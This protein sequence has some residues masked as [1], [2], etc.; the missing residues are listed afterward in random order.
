MT[1]IA[2]ENPAGL[3]PFEVLDQLYEQSCAAYGEPIGF[4]LFDVEFCGGINFDWLFKQVISCGVTEQELKQ[5]IDSGVVR[6]W[7]NPRGDHGFLLSTPEQVK[8]FKNLQRLGRYSDEELR[9]IMSRWDIDIECTLEV[10][11]YDDPQV[12]EIEHY[13]R[14]L[15]EH[16]DETRL[17]I[18]YLNRDILA[19]DERRSR[20]EHFN[21]ELRKCESAARRI[22]SS[23]S[24]TLTPDVRNNIHRALFRMRWVDEWVR[25]NN[26]DKFRSAILQGF[27]P[28]V[29]FSSYSQGSDGFTFD[30]IDWKT[31]LQRVRHLRSIGKR[32][33]SRTPDFD[34]TEIGMTLH[35]Q[36]APETYANIYERYQLGEL[37]K[38]IE[39]MGGDLW[40]PRKDLP[41]RPTCAEC[42]STFVRALAAKQYCSAKCRS[43]AKQR[44]Y[45]ERDPERA[46]LNQARYWKNYLEDC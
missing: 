1:E 18:N 21:D 25:I 24:V 37:A 27:S 32:F 45:R 15:A 14:R 29:F 17:Q 13:R 8:T 43:R 9:H 23:D 28:E 2:A 40:N 41:D 26:S 44:R 33:P 16:I 22:N 3:K 5:L 12:D 42:G 20:L 36:L 38:A 35:N 6:T 4:H 10:V 7:S 34:L 46:R 39:E 30:H 31:T 11:P 19:P